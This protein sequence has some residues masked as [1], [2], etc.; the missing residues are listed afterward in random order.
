MARPFNLLRARL[1]EHCIDQDKLCALLNR[2]PSY[3]SSRM[4]ARFPWNL[5]DMEIIMEQIGEPWG[6]LPKIFP[7]GGRNV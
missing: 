7:K 1:T 5:W 4:M 2:S 3:V 6:N